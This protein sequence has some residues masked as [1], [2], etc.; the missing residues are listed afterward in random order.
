M[1]DYIPHQRYKRPTNKWEEEYQGVND[2]LKVYYIES[3]HKDGNS[4]S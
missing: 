1:D 4:D 2:P 3:I